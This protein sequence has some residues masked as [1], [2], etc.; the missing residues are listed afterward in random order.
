MHYRYQ[1]DSSSKK[2]E[3]PNCSKRRFVR[4]VDLENNAYLPSHIGRCDREVKCGYHCTPKSVVA[5]QNYEPQ[6][7]PVQEPSIPFENFEASFVSEE[8]Y[9]S[10][11]Q[12][13][14]QNNF[15]KFLKAEL[16]EDV[17]QQLIE[18]YAIGTSKYWDG[19]TIFWQKDIKGEIR[20]G[21]VMLYNPE[22]G[23]RVK[24]PY[25]HIHW[26]H[27]L[28]L[29]KGLVEYF[30]LKQCLFG[31]HLLS[32]KGRKVV[33]VVESEKTAILMSYFYPKYEWLACGSLSN[34]NKQ[35]FEPLKGWSVRLYPDLGALEKWKEKAYWLKKQG[36]EIVVS[37]LLDGQAT[38]EEQ[39]RGLD[40]ADY[41][42]KDTLCYQELMQQELV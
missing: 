19:A 10:T 27:S 42:L 3:C 28:M 2:F 12:Y 17:S 6:L 16:G 37:S 26:A 18:R 15:V 20:T 11:L 39:A 5:Y 41:M 33:A 31:E 1:L 4:Y 38:E 34:I 8:L 35:L 24:E 32:K 14:T 21:K 23:H 7:A 30:F 9:K 13:Y 40:I 25:N 22:D 36:L 29:K